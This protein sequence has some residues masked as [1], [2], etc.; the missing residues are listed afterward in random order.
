MWGTRTPTGRGAEECEHHVSGLGCREEIDSVST[1]LGP[2]RAAL[3]TKTETR[4][5]PGAQV[6]RPL[7]SLLSAEGHGE[8]AEQQT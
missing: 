6:S 1:G 5:A 4:G 7:L 8:P 2:P 3:E